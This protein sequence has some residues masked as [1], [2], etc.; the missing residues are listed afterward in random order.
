M[1]PK[2]RAAVLRN[3]S[4]TIGMPGDEIVPSDD[5]LA[6]QQ[7]QAQANAEMAGKAGHSQDPPEGG[8][9]GDGQRDRPPGAGG[10][11]TPQQQGKPGEDSTKAQAPRTATFIQR[12]RGN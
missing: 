3:V 11:G 5:E 10:G 2:G 12:P 4:H 8:A 9:P 1:G 7:A 6:Q